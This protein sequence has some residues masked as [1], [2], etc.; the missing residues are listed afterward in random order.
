M[1]S[2]HYLSSHGLLRLPRLLGMRELRRRLGLWRLHWLRLVIYD[3]GLGRRERRVR[4]LLGDLECTL[5]VR[6]SKLRG[7]R[8]RGWLCWR[9]R[10]L[11]RRS[12][13]WGSSSMRLLSR[14]LLDGRLLLRRRGRRRCRLTRRLGRWLL[15]FYHRQV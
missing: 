4:F 1:V 10:W 13:F 11:R 7:F 14:C 12:W 9:S 8:C 3:G 2:G 5:M 6:W 15:G